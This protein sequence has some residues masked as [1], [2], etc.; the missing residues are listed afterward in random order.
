MKTLYDITVTTVRGDVFQ[1]KGISFSKLVQLSKQL[2]SIQNIE[3][4]K[5]YLKKI[6]Y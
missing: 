4:V 1:L 5:E 6:K 2:D 3:I